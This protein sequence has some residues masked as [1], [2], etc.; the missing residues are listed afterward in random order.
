MHRP[1]KVSRQLVGGSVQAA[2]VGKSGA[3]QGDGDGGGRRLRGIAEEQAPLLVGGSPQGDGEHLAEVVGKID[4]ELV[5]QLPRQVLEVGLVVLRHQNG[6]DARPHRAEHFL[7][8]AADRM[9]AGGEGEL[10]GH[11]DVVAGAANGGGRA[12]SGGH[13]GGGGG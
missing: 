6:A 12:H 2:G 5:A 9:H 7:V 10:A 3:A 1:V 4:L 8:Y 13:G 11:R